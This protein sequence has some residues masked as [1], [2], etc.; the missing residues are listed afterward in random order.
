MIYLDNAAT[1]GIKPSGVINA[2]GNALRQNSANPGRSGYK[3]SMETAYKIF[4]VRTRVKDFFGA[5]SEENVAFTL[6][7]THALN[8]VIK[9]IIADGGHIVTSD[10]EHNAVMRP[11]KKMADNRNVRINTVN[12][13][14]GDFEKTAEGFKNAIMPD[15]RLVICT[16][17]SNVTGAVNPVAQIGE[18]CKENGVPFAVD[19]AQSGAV[20]PIDMQKMNIDFLCVA[21]HKGLYAPMGTGILIAR[22]PLKNTV[23][24]G[25]T[26]TSSLDFSQPGEMPERFE[27]GT[28][29]V[30]GIFGIGAGIDFV[31]SKGIENIY[32]HE[33]ELIRYLYKK[34]QKNKKI[35]LYTPF[36]ENGLAVPVLSFNILGHSS[37]E[38]ADLLAR[39]NIAVRAGL[40]CAPTAHRKL[41][42]EM[43]G[44]VRVSTSLFNTKNDIDYLVNVLKFL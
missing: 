35:I 1:S 13:Y 8:C 43:E 16:H 27:S 19:A 26:G 36:P 40:H 42:T 15:T 5:D 23:I 31:K 25:G 3:V 18:I 29:N 32:R 28:V 39:K 4:S 14:Q 11:L 38:A 44:T 41:K 37:V 6:N 34:L 21:P 17:A 7:C 2:V 24:E 22:K 33:M 20:L 12:T 10:I 9:G 30:P